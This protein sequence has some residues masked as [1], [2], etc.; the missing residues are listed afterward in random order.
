MLSQELEDVEFGKRPDDL[1]LA[2]LWI[3]NNDARNVVILGDPAVRLAAAP[4]ATPVPGAAATASSI[5]PPGDGA[6]A[7]VPDV[8]SPSRHPRG[9]GRRRGRPRRARP[10]WHRRRRPTSTMPRSTSA[11]LDGVRKARHRVADSLNG[12]ARTLQEGLEDILAG[13]GGDRGRDRGRATTS[14]AP[15]STRRPGASPGPALGR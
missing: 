6:P 11:L 15:S 7:V 1:V 12:V 4:M 10:S 8:A 2:D 9:A 14:T 5:A 13:H 3:A